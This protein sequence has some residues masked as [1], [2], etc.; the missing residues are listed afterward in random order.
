MKKIIKKIKNAW[1]NNRIVF[2]F[3]VVLI[4]FVV[5]FSSMLISMY[6]GSGD[7]YG[8]RLAGIE[9]VKLDK[10]I[11]KDI[12]EKLKE[13]EIVD[14]VETDLKGKTYNILIYLVDNSDV[15]TIVEDA[16]NIIDIFTKD[17][18]NFYDIQV[19]ITSTIDTEEGDKTDK[20]IV[21]YRNSY[22][23]EFS[24]TNNR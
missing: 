11:G 15:N 1:N 7:K 5:V 17:E 24:W 10:N 9:D 4:T 6:A 16:E 20:T 14:D 8:N 2:L 13:N 22:K 21:G 23:E 12:E 18:L 3:T 19:F